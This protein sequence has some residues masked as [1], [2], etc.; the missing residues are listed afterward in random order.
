[1]KIS[2]RQIIRLAVLAVLA[3]ALYFVWDRTDNLVA[4][5]FAM[6]FAVLFCEG[7]FVAL[8]GL[9]RPKTHRAQTV[10]ALPLGQP[11]G[12]GFHPGIRRPRAERFAE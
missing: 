12:T 10:V 6:L 5:L 2:I 4:R 3:V 1:M 9:L 11:G 8:L 7:A